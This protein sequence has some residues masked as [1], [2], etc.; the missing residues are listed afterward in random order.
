MEMIKKCEVFQR[1]PDGKIHYRCTEG[2]I[3]WDNKLYVARWQGRQLNPSRFADLE[4]PKLLKTEDRGPLVEPSWTLAPTGGVYY[5]KTPSLFDYRG[6]VEDMIR[7][8]IET[9]ETLERHP[10]PH[11][12]RY[13]GY[14]EN[15]G[16][17]SG[18]CLER[19]ALTLAEKVDPRHLNKNEFL[20][21]G[22]L[23]VDDTLHLDGILSAVAHLHSLGLVHN[24]ITPSNILIAEDGGLL[25]GDFDSSCRI[26]KPLMDGSTGTKRTHGWHD[27]NITLASPQNDLDALKELQT[28]LIGSSTNDFIFK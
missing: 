15:R 4:N 7:R 25:L 6:E 28:W 21:S 3:R 10:H 17:V 11:V 20:S 2:I 22:R 12:V 23:L 19:C 26:G 9:Y 1:E 14:R 13:H 24:D 18:L 8:E 16:R 5:I 27:P